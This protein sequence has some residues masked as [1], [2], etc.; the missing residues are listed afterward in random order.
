MY[1]L[2][3]TQ[4]AELAGL[5]YHH[6]DY[7]YRLERRGTDARIT[8]A[9]LDIDRKNIEQHF[10]ALDALGVPFWVQNIAL[11]WS[12][13]WRN[14]ERGSLWQVLEKNGIVGGGNKCGK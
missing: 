6:A 1:I 3:H 5:A 12:E 8:D 11:C 14:Y 9:A 2:T 4:Y 13:N 7:K 10:A